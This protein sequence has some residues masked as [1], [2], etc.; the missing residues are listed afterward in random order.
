[1]I[2]Q[3]TATKRIGQS[4][5]NYGSAMKTP[6]RDGKSKYQLRQ[7]SMI[8]QQLDMMANGKYGKNAELIA[9]KRQ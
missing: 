1:M 5:F 9:L 4:G 3:Q 7:N 6:L 2:M 8:G